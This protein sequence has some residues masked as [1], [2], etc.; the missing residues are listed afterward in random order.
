MCKCVRHETGSADTRPIWGRYNYVRWDMGSGSYSSQ[1]YT[2]KGGVWILRADVHTLGVGAVTSGMNILGNCA[3]TSGLWTLGGGTG[4]GGGGGI[5]LRCWRLSR[6]APFF[7]FSKICCATVE[8][9]VGGLRRIYSFV[10][11]HT[12]AGICHGALWWILIVR[13]KRPWCIR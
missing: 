3:A 1:G 12:T 7:A 2:C 9:M 11:G 6:F 5:L 13:H 10:K 8:F 4:G